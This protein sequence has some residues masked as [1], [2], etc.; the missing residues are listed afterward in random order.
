MAFVLLRPF[1]WK[2]LYLQTP[3]HQK[4]QNHEVDHWSNRPLEKKPPK[5]RSFGV[6]LVISEKYGSCFL[7]CLADTNERGNIRNSTLLWVCQNYLSL[8]CSGT[9][10]VFIAT[11]RIDSQTLNGTLYDF[12]HTY[13]DQSDRNMIPDQAHV[14]W[15]RLEN[16]WCDIK[17]AP[18][19]IINLLIS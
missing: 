16:V 14:Q 9:L 18:F 8:Y 17:K 1:R 13:R 6:K 12:T 15:K 11:R 2:G 4:T 19:P 7:S 3:Q 5:R 10:I